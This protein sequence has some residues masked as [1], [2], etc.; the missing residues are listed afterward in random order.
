MGPRKSYF[1]DRLVV[2]YSDQCP[3]AVTNGLVVLQSQRCRLNTPAAH[4][5]LPLTPTLSALSA[6][7]Y[8]LPLTHT[9][10][11]ITSAVVHIPPPPPPPP[12]TGVSTAI[13]RQTLPHTSAAAAV[14]WR[15]AP[16]YSLPSNS[17]TSLGNLLPAA[18]LPDTVQMQVSDTA[19]C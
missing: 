11:G 16:Q 4:A 3:V 13:T 7:A 9:M 12:N 18:I 2:C 17:T 15:Y 19:A 1:I 5:L 6:A 14:G 10:T 8:S